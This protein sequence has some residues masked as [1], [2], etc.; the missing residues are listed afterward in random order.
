[1]CEIYKINSFFYIFPIDTLPIVVD[2]TLQEILDIIP[3]VTNQYGINIHAVWQ[4]T[5]MQY[6]IQAD[7][8]CM[9]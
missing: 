9:C 4:N 3:D 5:V 6:F 1:M 8:A 2:Y 7:Q